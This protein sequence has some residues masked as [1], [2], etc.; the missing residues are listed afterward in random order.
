M[1]VNCTDLNPIGCL[2]V[3]R[4]ADLDYGIRIQSAVFPQVTRQTDTLTDIEKVQI[5]CIQVGRIRSSDTTW[6]CNKII[7]RNAWQSLAYSPLGAIVSPPSEY[8]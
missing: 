5:T 6:Q 2:G 8:L 3:S 4:L 7:T 1:V